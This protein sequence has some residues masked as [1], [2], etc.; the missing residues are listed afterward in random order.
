MKRFLNA[1]NTVAL[2]AA[3]TLWRVYLASA[4]QLHPDEAYY[5]LWSRNLDISYFDHPPMVAYFIRLTTL[6]SQ[7]EMWVRLSGPLVSLVASV[8]MWRLAL[9]LFDS[10]AVAAGSVLLFNVLPLT[11]LGLTVVTPDVP[12]LLFWALGV[13]LFW[14]ILRTQRVGLWYGLGLVFGLA[15]LSK[16]TAVLLAPCVLLYLLLTDERR[17]LKTPH[18][19]LAVLLGFACF[20]PVLVWNSQHD[21]VSFTFQFRN[22]LGSEAM[23]LAHVAEY[24]GAQMLIT[25]PIVWVVGAYAGVVALVRRDKAMLFLVC[26]SLPVIAFFGLSSLRK[27]AGANWPASAYFSFSILATHT[28]LV[29]GSRL[30]RV[31]WGLSL[32]CALAVSMLVTL[33]ARFHVIPL[34]RW[35][36][37]AAM[38]D[39]TNGFYGWRELVAGLRQYPQ[40]KF[41]VT[42]SHQLSA[43]IMYYSQESLPARTAHITR[44]SQF[45]LWP[46]TQSMQGTNGLY[47]WSE[48]DFIG[49]DEAK[50]AS[51]EVSKPIPIYRAGRVIRTYHVIPGI[52]TTV[53]PF[54]GN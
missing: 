35:S 22:G 49:Q 11:M 48:D 19:Y 50:F 5:W 52:A 47:V 13:C 32:V 53:P 1:R 18:P 31:V 26:M 23:S 3:L 30:K 6:F 46:W 37:A 42:P 8:L 40:K 44:P 28:C 14:Q 45:N 36:Q 12:V 34:E 4:L 20:A 39:V 7:S 9:Q 24:L 29:N 10:V 43:E 2:V 15:L 27:V 21:W 41:A 25:S 38:A 16:Y 33:H 54:P 51:P 17:W